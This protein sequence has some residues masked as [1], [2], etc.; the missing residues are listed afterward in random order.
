VR[1]G[2]LGRERPV[3]FVHTG[4]GISNFAWAEQILREPPLI[5]PGGS[6]D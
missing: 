2:K 5:G 3:I 4:G 6:V 1:D